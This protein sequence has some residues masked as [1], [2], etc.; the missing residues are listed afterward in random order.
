M[1]VKII[2]TEKPDIFSSLN[3]NIRI[4]INLLQVNKVTSHYFAKIPQKSGLNHELTLR[5]KDY[6]T[7]GQKALRPGDVGLWG[8]V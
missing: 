4:I 7:W 6:D 8:Q 2:K 5:W 3:T 1:F